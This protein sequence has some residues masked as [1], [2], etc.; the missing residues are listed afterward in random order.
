METEDAQNESDPN[1]FVDAQSF[2]DKDNTIPVSKFDFSDEDDAV[3]EIRIG[4]FAD[5]AMRQF[6]ERM[7]FFVLLYIESSSFLDTSDEIWEVLI[8]SRRCGARQQTL[9]YLT[10]Y[11]FYAYA[12]GHDVAKRLRISQV[13]IFPPFQRQSLGFEALQHVYRMAV[14]RNFVEVNVE[15]PARGMKVL[16]DSTDV[17]NA[18]IHGCFDRDAFGVCNLTSYHAAKLNGK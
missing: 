18:H 13:M 17:Y 4:S 7:Q 12:P 6:H 14:Y 15:D 16:R 9:G 8:L 2:V 5:G 3:Y 11:K 1:L 10:L